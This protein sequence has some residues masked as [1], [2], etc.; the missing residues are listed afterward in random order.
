MD[1]TD[2]QI[3]DAFRRLDHAR[4][5]LSA[6]A[7]IGRAA[8][9]RRLTSRVV[10]ASVGAAALATA[11]LAMPGSPVSRWIRTSLARTD[12]S[13]VATPP[14]ALAPARDRSTIAVVPG[15]NFEL[16]F[17]TTQSAGEIRVRFVQDAE[18]SVRA[19]GGEARYAVLPAGLAVR[20]A[21]SS[22]SY[23]VQVPDTQ[24]GLRI[25]IGA[26]VVFTRTAG[27][28]TPGLVPDPQGMYVI[29][30]SSPNR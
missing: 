17:D 21:G 11:A 28:V 10:A 7:V 30:L 26:L 18:L 16:V 13:A 20:N 22:A 24:R 8:A 15:P 19:E 3:D 4:P 23:A 6:S 12:V 1:P 9:R 29:P 14:S 25:R 5:N 2:R 27:R